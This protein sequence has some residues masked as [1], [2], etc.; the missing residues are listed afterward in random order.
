MK[1]ENPQD[2]GF[3]LVELIVVIAIM[4][5]FIGILAPTYLS[6]VEKT[7]K[8]IDDNSAEEIRR[9]TETIILSGEYEVTEAVVVTFSSKGIQVTAAPYAAK[10]EDELKILF[11][12]FP[13]VVPKS[14]AR[15]NMTYSVAIDAN[16]ANTYEVTGTWK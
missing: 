5:V 6:Y 13:S 11:P 7:R 8:G 3:S 9:A 1:K 12:N 2:Q 14:K 4:A 16:V 15:K 10:L